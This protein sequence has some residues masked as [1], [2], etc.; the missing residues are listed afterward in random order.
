MTI[1]KIFV[2]MFSIAC[3]FVVCYA[4]LGFELNSIDFVGMFNS[5]GNISVDSDSALSVAYALQNLQINIQKLKDVSYTGSIF[6]MIQT[7]F[8]QIGSFLNVLRYTLLVLFDNLLYIS[9]C[10]L[11]IFRYLFGLV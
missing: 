1:Y 5:F 6:N 9:Q 3:M 11:T 8:N 10:I 4:F 7:F 2:F